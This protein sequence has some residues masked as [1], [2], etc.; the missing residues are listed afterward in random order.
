MMQTLEKLAIANAIQDATWLKTGMFFKQISD[1]LR[2]KLLQECLDQKNV[3]AFEELLLNLRQESLVI[4]CNHK[5]T[6]NF[7]LTVVKC[8]ENNSAWQN[9]RINNIDFG[10]CDI[11]KNINSS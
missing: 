1:Q 5:F 8:I 10:G 2:G 4:Q 3:A 6:D 11:G 9:T 7:A